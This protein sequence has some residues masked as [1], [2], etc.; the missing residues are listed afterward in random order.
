MAFAWKGAMQTLRIVD[1]RVIARILSILL[2]LT[3]AVSAMSRAR[4]LAAA[5]GAFAMGAA[6][7]LIVMGPCAW[8]CATT[9][10]ISRS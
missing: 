6:V 10:A 9:F 8:T 2:A 7:F 3:L 4:G 5:L 1:R